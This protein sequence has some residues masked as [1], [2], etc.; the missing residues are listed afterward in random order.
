M[1]QRLKAA[2]VS[3]GRW[4][5]ERAVRHIEKYPDRH[6]EEELR[7]EPEGTVVFIDRPDGTRIHAIAAGKG[8]TVVLAH[9]FMLTRQAWNVLAAKLIEAGYRVVCFD[10]RGHGESTIGKDGTRAKA[11]ASDYRAVLEHFEVE[12]GALVGHSMGGFLALIALL[13]DPEIQK[14]LGGLV[15]ASAHAG[16]LLV[17]NPQNRLQLP[18]YRYGVM[19]KLLATED[20]NVLMG[21]FLYGDRPSAAEIRVINDMLGRHALDVVMPIIEDMVALDY[22]G[23]LSRI[24][25]PTVVLCGKKDRTC[26]PVRTEEIAAKI[27]G[28]RLQ[29]IDGAGH[30]VNWEAS[31]ALVSAVRELVP[32]P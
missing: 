24:T 13:E 12:G 26:P 15:L 32:A 17:G 9:G 27:P 14:R 21:R 22:Y 29:W 28:A 23:R 1:L 30:M 19:H 4:L 8:P 18:L 7:R 6:S 3:G 2:G 31:D 20:V 10:Q 5:L 16:A 11:M 25:V